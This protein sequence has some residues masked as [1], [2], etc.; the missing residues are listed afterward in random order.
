MRYGIRS[1][2]TVVAAVAVACALVVAAR[3][4]YYA[5]RHQAESLLTKVQGISDVKLHSH[6]DV[7]EE[8]NSSS[9]TV[10]GHPGSIVQIG[11]L[12]RYEDEG[13][14]SVSRIGKWKFRVSGRHYGGAYRADTGEPV[15]SDY[16][17]GSISLGPNSPYTHLIPFEVNTLQDLADHYTEL[18]ELF[19]TWPREAEPGTVTLDDGTAQ[20]YYVVDQ[21]E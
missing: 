7:T 16:L 10:E 18:V 6:V 17:G 1:L 20:Y 9:F 14:F 3:N 4:T 5:D 15:E 2:L 11:G 13:R 8:V 19:E 21:G 12:R